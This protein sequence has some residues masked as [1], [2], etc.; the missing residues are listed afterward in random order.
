MEVSTMRR[1]LPLPGL[2]ALVSILAACGGGGTAASGG[3]A[4]SVP[5]PASNASAATPASAAAS[6]SSDLLADL[7]VGGRTMHILCVGPVVAGRPTVVFESGLGGDAGQWSDV[8]HSLDGTVRACAYD[9]AGEGRSPAAP[10]GRTTSD[11]VADLRTLLA[12]AKVE[13]PYVL[14]GFSLGGWN[15]MVHADDHPADVV[16][17]VMVDVRPPAA[18]RRWLEALPPAS[19]T[20]SEAIRMARD[21]ST[22]FDTDPS[23]NPEGLRLGDSATE[24][25]ETAGFGSKPLVVLAAAD[26]SAIAEGFEPALGRRLV[27]IWWEGQAE[28]ASRS[29]A[30]RLV[31]IEDAT[32]ELPVEQ[33]DAIAD[34]IR[35]VLGD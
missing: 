6:A 31:K 28:I 33:P 21:E 2:I 27:D 11:Q 10:V 8:I 19:A 13:P 15:V 35:E 16:G 12:A 30:G 9:R 7:D 32:H 26:T 34:A 18:S 1:P 24:A 5:G 20:E 25:I 22:T 17:A 29:T 3:P 4:A 14:V 23:L